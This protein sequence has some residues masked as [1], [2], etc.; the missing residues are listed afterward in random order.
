MDRF[1]QAPSPKIE[2]YRAAKVIATEGLLLKSLIDRK[3]P[4]T[5]S[6]AAYMLGEVA[7]PEST[8][9]I[10]AL[11]N[12]LQDPD[13]R[14]PYQAMRSL[15]RLNALTIK[16]LL[17]FYEA[18]SPLITQYATQALGVMPGEQATEVLAFLAANEQASVAIRALA[19]RYLGERE[20]QDTS[21]QLTD[22]LLDAEPVLRQHA[23]LALGRMGAFTSVK[24]LYQTLIDEDEDVRMPFELHWVY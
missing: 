2:A 10:Q 8:D 9:T 12:A 14:V 21:S 1:V 7:T 4:E 16:E 23:A 20:A 24:S 17:P 15:S 3:F 11:R 18:D 22:L 5:R 6:G 19:I 13:P